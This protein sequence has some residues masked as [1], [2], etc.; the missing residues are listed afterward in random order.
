MP[1]RLLLL[2]A[3]SLAITATLL[4]YYFAETRAT[5][6]P[7]YGSVLQANGFQFQGGWVPKWL[8]ASASNIREVHD[9]DSGRQ[10]LRF[11]IPRIHVPIFL[12]SSQPLPR[13]E[14]RRTGVKRPLRVGSGWPDELSRVPMATPRS[15][16]E[17]RRLPDTPFCAAVDDSTGVIVAWTCAADS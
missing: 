14:A 10:W 16:L 11:S 17:F 8:P 3:L 1:R 15:S 7:T 4:V 9:I 5:N 2:A 12:A 6:Y 13:A